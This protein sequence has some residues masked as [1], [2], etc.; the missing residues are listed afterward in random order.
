MTGSP[1]EIPW[2][3]LREYGVYPK[4]EL[5]SGLPGIA[6][7]RYTFLCLSAHSDSWSVVPGQDVPSSAPRSLSDEPSQA[8]PL[9]FAFPPSPSPAI[10]SPPAQ[11]PHGHS[12]VGASTD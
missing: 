3:V 4:R 12:A 6:S 5:C 9:A 7:L 1:Q 11:L 2:E 10:S 8:A